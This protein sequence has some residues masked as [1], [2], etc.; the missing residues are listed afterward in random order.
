MNRFSAEQLAGASSIKQ[1]MSDMGISLNEVR[2]YYKLHAPP[3]K[4]A[5]RVLTIAQRVALNQIKLLVR[6]HSVTEAELNAIFKHFDRSGGQTDEIGAQCEEQ[7]PVGV[8]SICD[9][10]VNQ[11]GGCDSG[12]IPVGSLPDDAEPLVTA[13]AA[14]FDASAD[15]DGQEAHRSEATQP[16]EVEQGGRKRMGDSGWVKY[17]HP[18]TKETWDGAGSKPDWLIKA[19]LADGMLLRDLLPIENFPLDEE[20]A[21]LPAGVAFDELAVRFNLKQAV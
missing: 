11:A 3:P 21:G 8:Q 19:L 5:R 6:R 10:P 12:A 17:R 7:R 15:G 18:V 1:L 16:V 2:S 20:T 4:Q 13:A 14:S 9:E